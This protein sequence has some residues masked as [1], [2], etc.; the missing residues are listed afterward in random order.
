MTL[1]SAVHRTPP[2]EIVSFHLS[3]LNQ[4]LQRL[5]DFND[6]A[7]NVWTIEPDMIYA[8]R[9]L[10]CAWIALQ[11]TQNLL[12]QG[13]RLIGHRTHVEMCA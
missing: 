11:V 13:V 4:L 12:L 3:R 6:C 2:G 8:L 5:L 9:C 1:N 7:R 10:R